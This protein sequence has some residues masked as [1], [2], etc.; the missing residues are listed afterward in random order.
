MK[1]QPWSLADLGSKP[2][3]GPYQLDVSSSFGKW[4]PSKATQLA[5]RSGAD[6]EW[7]RNSSPDLTSGLCAFPT[8]ANYHTQQIFL[9][10]L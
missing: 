8:I 9:E 4:R 7:R 3:V 6:A 5:Q 1:P 10:H 2:R